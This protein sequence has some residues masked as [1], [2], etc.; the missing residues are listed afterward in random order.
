[1]LRKRAP[2]IAVL[3]V[4]LLVGL[5]VAAYGYDTSRDDLIADGVTVAGVDVGG[6]RADRAGDKLREHQRL[7]PLI[8]A[9]A[10]QYRYERAV[11][12]FLRWSPSVNRRRQEPERTLTLYDDLRADELI[13][14]LPSLEPTALTALRD[15]EVDN[16]SRRTVLAAIDS[17]LVR[18]KTS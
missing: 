17:N 9:N 3:S 4:A 18:Q 8:R 5:A 1:M 7:D 16:R 6:M 12:D 10:G 14:L 15:H 11:E 2:L 13:A